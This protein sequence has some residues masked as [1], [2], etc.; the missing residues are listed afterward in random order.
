MEEPPDFNDE[1]VLDRIEGSMIGL[2][3]G[4]ALGAHVEFRSHQFLVEYPVT[5]FQA[6]GPWSLQKGQ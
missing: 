3:I 1:K 4:D 2:A 5:D 6:G